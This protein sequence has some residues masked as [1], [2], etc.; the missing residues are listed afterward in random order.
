[1]IQMKT[2]TREMEKL[3]SSAEVKRPQ[4]PREI[5]FDLP[6]GLKNKLRGY[7]LVETKVTLLVVKELVQCYRAPIF[8]R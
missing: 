3:R 2:T 6:H 4:T 7:I 1:M 5:L 8:M